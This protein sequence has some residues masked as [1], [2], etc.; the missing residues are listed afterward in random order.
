MSE[1][2]DTSNAATAAKAMAKD[3]RS[4][5]SKIGNDVKLPLPLHSSIHPPPPPRSSKKAATPSPNTEGKDFS[6]SQLFRPK[7]DSNQQAGATS[8]TFKE[9]E[10][11]AV[12]LVLSLHPVGVLASGFPTTVPGEVNWYRVPAARDGPLERLNYK[13]SLYIPVDGDTCICAQ[14]VPQGDTYMP[15]SFAEIQI[16]DSSMEDIVKVH[17]DVLDSDKTASEILL[18]NLSETKEALKAALQ[19]LKERD[20]EIGRL[21]AIDKSQVVESY[22]PSIALEEECSHLNTELSTLK[23]VIEKLKEDKGACLRDLDETRATCQA[24]AS[25]L[26]QAEER[27]SMKQ[28]RIEE[29]E[30]LQFDSNGLADELEDLRAQAEGYDAIKKQMQQNSEDMEK[31]VN[32]L[33]QALKKATKES[34][35]LGKVQTERDELALTLETVKSDRD[36]LRTELE[37]SNQTRYALHMELQAARKE[38]EDFQTVV[39]EPDVAP[40][41]VIDSSVELAELRNA[42]NQ[43]T[44]RVA[45]L[46]ELLESATTELNGVR[47]QLVATVSTEPSLY[48]DP[49][50][51]KDAS[52]LK[53]Q[54]EASEMACK[55][56]KQQV[57]S[58]KKDMSKLL[59]KHNIIGNEKAASLHESLREQLTSSIKEATL[60]RNAFEQ[61]VSLAGLVNSTHPV[62]EQDWRNQI[63]QL[64]GVASSLS[65]ALGD[66]V[67]H[68]N[69]LK[70]IIIVLQEKLAMYE[71][72]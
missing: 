7:T 53:E 10:S 26:E 14:W 13:G 40:V 50:H 60:Y 49:V 27:E 25:Q 31:R 19:S 17:I 32:E 44:S 11:L 4:F 16:P 67:L 18:G 57:H 37:G 71:S 22:A 56:L 51:Q 42:L 52:D 48:K 12:K 15:S 65:D 55:S 8:P 2:D 66:K 24:I 38:V 58:L 64:Q 28:S 39:H 20:V 30:S 33:T 63:R 43:E 3:V 54:L 70:D 62:V 69:A 68:N 41:E 72:S 61:Q 45:K 29:L 36:R 1:E 46:N 9:S 5:F 6:F 59:Q 35:K 34:S 21:T 23:S 47:K